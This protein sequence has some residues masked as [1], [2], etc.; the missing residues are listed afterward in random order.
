MPHTK[1]KSI[2]LGTAAAVLTVTSILPVQAAGVLS[3]LYSGGSTLAEKVYRDAMNCY[4]SHS[5]TDLTVTLPHPPA[6]CDSATPYNANVESLYVGVGSGNGRKA[7]E[8]HDPTLFVTG[9]KVPDA[10]PVASTTDFG[11]YYGTGVGAGWVPASNSSDS[12]PTVSF[13]D[14]DDP[15]AAADITAYNTNNTNGW[16]PAVQFPGLITTVTIPFHPTATWTEKG[17]KP[18]GGGN[19][20]LVDLSTDTLCGILTGV[21]TDWSDPAFKT[22]N[23]GV[24]LGSG[25]ITVVYR[26]DSSGTTYITSNALIHQCA[27]TTHPVPSSWTSATGNTGGANDNWF[28]NL[29]TAGLLPANFVGAS[30]SGGVK[31]AINSTVGAVGYVS[32]DFARPID[33]AGAETANLQT[34]ASISGTPVFKAP[35]A[36]NGTAIVGAAK[37]PSFSKNSCPGDGDGICADDPLNWGVL[38][39]TPASSAAYPIGGFTFVAM[40]SCYNSATELANLV[41]TTAGSLGYLRWYYG[42]TTENGSLVKNSL[43]A[44]GFSEVPGGW[45]SGIKKLLT[46]NK[47]T[48]IGQPGQANTACAKVTGSG[49]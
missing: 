2:I 1:L 39:P 18:A 29:H 15:L 4:G 19:S 3:P 30:G 45:I 38:F 22:N 36:K 11:P 47:P 7:L 42:S 33:P 31:A 9:G 5:G 21:I 48:K 32:P 34:W 41:G 20:S 44:N 12:F 23:G 46:T 6:I 37:A 13:I 25:A 35:T 43:T 49:A 40:Y 24:Q 8:A 27:S 10:V 26:S 17:K 14:S 16:G 28:P